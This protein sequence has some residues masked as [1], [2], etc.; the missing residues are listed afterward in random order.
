MRVLLRHRHLAEWIPV[1][2][3][4]RGNQRKMRANERDE[5]D[6]RLVTVARR[7]FA[8]PDLRPRGDLAVVRGVWSFAGP[9]ELGDLPRQGPLGE[10]LAHQ[11]HE[12]ALALDDVHR[13]DLFG[14]AVVVLRMA[15]EVKLADRNHAM[16][17]ITQAM[18]PARN[19]AVVGVSIV[20]E[21]YLVHVFAGRKRRA[22]RHAHRAG[23]VGRAEQ[24]APCRQGVDVRRSDD[25]MP[26]RPHDFGVVLIGHDEEE[27]GR[28]HASP[29]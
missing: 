3:L 8:Q 4:G 23:G 9:G 20:P 6:P 12:I 22:R 2:E 27:V 17:A 29:W 14:K 7:L 1:I 16:A 24:C 10:I 26:T 25:R 11:P 21:A 15:A 18:M 28:F 19:R 13:D 5:K